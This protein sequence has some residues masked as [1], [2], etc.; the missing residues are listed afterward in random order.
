MGRAGLPA[1]LGAELVYGAERSSPGQPTNRTG[2]M[3]G[4]F[5]GCSRMARVSSASLRFAAQL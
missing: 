3:P 2:T 1:V 4:P 5:D